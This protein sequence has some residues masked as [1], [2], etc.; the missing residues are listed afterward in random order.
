MTR[1]KAVA[2]EERGGFYGLLVP[3]PKCTPGGVWKAHQ[4]SSGLGGRRGRT[5]PAARHTPPSLA[6]A[7]N[8]LFPQVWPPPCPRGDLG[9]RDAGSP[10]LPFCP[11]ALLP[12][13]T[14]S[15]E[16]SNLAPGEEAAA[17][18]A[19]RP[20]ASGPGGSGRPQDWGFCAPAGR[21]GRAVPARKLEP[22]EEGR[23]V[24]RQPPAG[25]R[26][27]ACRPSLPLGC[28][29]PC[30]LP[31]RGRVGPSRPPPVAPRPGLCARLLSSRREVCP[32][33]SPVQ[34]CRSPAPLQIT[35]LQEHGVIPGVRVEGGGCR[36]G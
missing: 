19:A 16:K 27:G 23:A 5:A 25:W 28:P 21:T 9:A 2:K 8:R 1:L 20:A 11:S 30:P 18:A 34:F 12:H 26:C 17:P 14:S 32:S 10:S 29:C 35:C 7:S 31:L 4:R 22:A 13:P 33:L 3:L 15:P 36:P 24:G 6:S